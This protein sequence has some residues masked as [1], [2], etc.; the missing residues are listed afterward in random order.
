MSLIPIVIDK[1]G[2]EERA[3]D[4]YSRLLQ[5]RVIFLGTQVTDESANSMEARF[6]TARARGRR[7]LPRV[8]PVLGNDGK[9]SRYLESR[10]SRG[11]EE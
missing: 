1:N 11:A 7:A 9:R 10:V 5:D 4:I 3:M 8:V 6:R 2:R